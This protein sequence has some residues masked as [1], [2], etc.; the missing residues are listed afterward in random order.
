[1]HREWLKNRPQDYSPQVRS[2]IEAGLTIP[3]TYY[4]DAMRLRKQLTDQFLSN[5][6][7]NVDVIHMPV[8]CGRVPS[9]AETDIDGSGDKVR[10]LVSRLTTLTRPINLFGLPSISIPCGFDP[11]G[12]PLS[13]QL[14]GYPF[15]E[16]KL[17]NIAHT[18]E[19]V[20]NYHL[21]EPTL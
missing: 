17:L 15:T 3:A 12:L 2:R 19:Q 14:I 7:A 18:F 20:T 13:F 9:I 8:M 21:H 5:T 11:L 4:L 16:A 6:M 10:A 1:M